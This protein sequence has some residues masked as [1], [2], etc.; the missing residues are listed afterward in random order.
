LKVNI[1]RNLKR[2]IRQLTKKEKPKAKRHPKQNP[3]PC[4]VSK[5]KIK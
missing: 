1:L 3:L 2:A 4:T 5:E